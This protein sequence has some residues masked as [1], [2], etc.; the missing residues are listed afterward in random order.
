MAENGERTEQIN[1][2]LRIG[3]ALKTTCQPTVKVFDERRSA[4]PHRKAADYF[5]IGR[6]RPT[7]K[8][9]SYFGV[10]EYLLN[11]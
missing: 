11:T 6:I 9:K 4:E 1:V 3:L 7:N 10:R 2:D 8:A 5:R